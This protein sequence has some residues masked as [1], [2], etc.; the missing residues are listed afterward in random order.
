VEND[1][2]NSM[3]YLDVDRC[4]M[5]F[6]NEEETELKYHYFSDGKPLGGFNWAELLEKR[7]IVILAEAGAGKTAEMLERS[8]KLRASGQYSFYTTINALGRKQLRDCLITRNIQAEFDTWYSSTDEAIIFADSLDEARLD[9]QSFQ[10]ALGNIEK[11]VGDALDRVTIIISGRVSD[12]RPIEDLNAFQNTL[13]NGIPNRQP[14][15][16]NKS[17]DWLLLGPVMKNS[18][19]DDEDKIPLPDYKPTVVAIAP[20]TSDQATK[21]AKWRGVKNSDKFLTAIFKAEAQTLA[22]RP[23]D[24]FGLVD[25]WNK[26]EKIG[27]KRDILDWSIRRRLRET[28]QNRASDT[29]SESEAMNGAKLIASS[30]TFGKK[31]FISWPIN[32]SSNGLDDLTLNPRDL[33]TDWSNEKQAHLLNRAVFD[34]ASLGRVRFHHRSVQEYLTALWLLDL[35]SRGCPRRKIWDLLSS[36]LYGEYVLRP[37]FRPVC[38]WLGQLDEWF[39]RKISEIAPEVLIEGGDPS[40]I[41]VTDRAQLLEM[42]CKLYAD[43][44]YGGVSIY[45][46]QIQRLADASLS[47]K[48]K[49]LW[50]KS[51]KS[52]ENRKLL[53]R[54]IWVGV[55]KDCADIVGEASVGRGRDYEKSIAIQAL[56]RIGT[57]TQYENLKNHLVKFASSL[58]SRVVGHA[59]ETLYPDHLSVTELKEVLKKY[60]KVNKRKRAHSRSDIDYNISNICKMPDKPDS[61]ALVSAFAD[62]VFEDPDTFR[63][64]REPHSS[65]FYWLIDPAMTV[66][67][68]MYEH[69]A[70]AIIVDAELTEM[71]RKFSNGAAYAGSSSNDGGKKLKSVIR[72]NRELNR[73]FFWNSVH[74]AQNK[75]GDL[76]WYRQAYELGELWEIREED[77]EWA[78]K[79]IKDKTKANDRFIATNVALNIWAI[80]RSNTIRLGQIKTAAGTERGLC[81]EILKWENPPENKYDDDPRWKRRQRKSEKK[82][83]KVKKNRAL[84]W[85]RFRDE[86]VQNPLLIDGTENFGY[87]YEMVRWSDAVSRKSET[88][89]YTPEPIGDAFSQPVLLKTKEELIRFWRSYYPLYPSQVGQSEINAIRVGLRGIDLEAAAEPNWA[90]NLSNDDVIL[91]TRYALHERLSTLDSIISLWC[92]RESLVRPV[93]EKELEWEFTRLL[94]KGQY[95]YYLSYCIAHTKEPFLSLAASICMDVLERSYPKNDES[96]KNAIDTITRANID[97]SARLAKVAEREFLQART[98][99]KKSRWMAVWIASA[100][101]V[102]VDALEIWINKGKRAKRPVKMWEVLLNLYSRHDST[103]TPPYLNF[104]N[105]A[106]LEKLVVL[107]HRYVDPNDDA[108]HEGSYTPDAR[109][110]VE[111]ARSG[112]FSMITNIPGE[113]TYNLILRLIAMPEFKAMKQFYRVSARSRAISDADITSWEPEALVAFQNQFEKKPETQRELHDIV[114]YRIDDIFDDWETGDYSSKATLRQEHVKRADETVVQLALANELKQRRHGVYTLEREPEIINAKKPDIRINSDAVNCGIPIEIKVADSWSLRELKEAIKDQLIGLYMRSKDERYGVLALTYHGKKQRWRHETKGQKSM[115]IGQLSFYLQ[116]YANELVKTDGNLERIEVVTVDLS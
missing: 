103:F 38:S 79:D 90:A 107:A 72:N 54:L 44:D 64:K 86:V 89:L 111:R 22:N 94:K 57:K 31:R 46:E 42:F 34:P 112:L 10:T 66:L 39:R 45:L 19:G 3:P 105:L 73:H 12:W 28:N 35:V 6:S 81:E 93:L 98:I 55:M 87:L 67:A 56:S 95:L 78:L 30:L 27:G 51:K 96:L 99:K 88:R 37:T 33:L 63:P 82:W 110:N 115:N 2:K 5:P 74:R 52:A 61:K 50:K 68:E 1:L 116:A 8:A 43:K 75:D 24:L 18:E 104:D 26:E 53:L 65:K 14:E 48:I 41:S 71:A 91:A 36:N 76:G 83:N 100:G 101:L 20:L 109:D 108:V 84:S 32:P 25:L 15:T 106:A 59:I 29:L 7:R 17:K 92:E 23:Q 69:N 77:L 97:H 13:C 58:S 9:G 80:D 47:L 11:A 40:I 102:A 70:Q 114:L 21:L 16:K 4:F 113:N 60:G 85:L 49:N 62:L